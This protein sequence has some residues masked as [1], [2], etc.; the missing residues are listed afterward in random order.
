MKINLKK[1]FVVHPILFAIYPVVFLFSYNVKETS[2]GE[3]VLPLLL[4]AGISILMWLV[5]GFII[6]DK[7]K[8][9]I[10]VSLAFVLFFS[11]GHV[12]NALLW[13]FFRHRY[14]L[15]IWVLVFVSGVYLIIRTQKSLNKITGFLNFISIIL[16]AISAVQI[17]P[18]LLKYHGAVEEVQI[19]EG[20]TDKR[21]SLPDIYYIILDGYARGDVLQELFD[22]DNSDFLEYLSQK[23][24][25]VAE[26]SLSNYCQTFLSLASSLN[27]VYLDDFAKEIGDNPLVWAPMSKRIKYSFV[28]GFLKQKG[29][30]LISF[31]SGYH[32]TE[33]KNSDIYLKPEWSLSEFENTLINTTPIPI[34]LKKLHTPVSDFQ[35][36]IHRERINF[37]FD[38]LKKTAGSYSPAFYF[39]HIIAPHPPFVFDENGDGVNPNRPFNITGGMGLEEIARNMGKYKKDYTAQ[40][41]YINVKTK[42]VIDQI[43]SKSATPPIIVMQA[44]HGSGMLFDVDSHENSNLKE[45]FSIFNAYYL[46]GDGC[47]L[48]Y[49]KISPV[50]TFRVIFNHYFMAEYQILEDRSFFSSSDK[51]LLFID[52]TNQIAVD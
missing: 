38:Q 17:L 41:T 16:I 2:P 43:I 18:N 33:I 34:L 27:F 26:K 6:R 20:K 30:T 5:L 29:Y 22:Y 36:N 8:S 47:E 46:P 19:M 14:L 52:I 39:V 9:A 24:F 25:Y 11:Y 49:D 10:I 7:E 48:L 42:E 35:Y 23:G 45:R 37:V 15:S 40:L 4:L 28:H 12:M 13:T 3:V 51:P 44:D 1:P 21:E 31:A 32:H 50:N